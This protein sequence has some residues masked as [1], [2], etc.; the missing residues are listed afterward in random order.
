MLRVADEDALFG[1]EEMTEADLTAWHT[2]ALAW[3]EALANGTDEPPF[4]ADGA[5]CLGRERRGVAS[6]RFVCRLATAH[7]RIDCAIALPWPL[8]DEE[9][10]EKARQSV[11][12]VARLVAILLEAEKSGCLLIG[13]DPAAGL[14]VFADEGHASYRVTDADGR[15]VRS[16]SG[17]QDLLPLLDGLAMTSDDGNVILVP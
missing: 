1:G 12:A 15:T 9:V 11:C 10:R 16:G 5:S 13:N 8:A 6:D 17:W 7:L 2:L 4:A 3:S 14:E